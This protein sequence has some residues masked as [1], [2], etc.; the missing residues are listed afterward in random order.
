MADTTTDKTAPLADA[1]AATV[2]AAAVTPTPPTPPAEPV[3]PLSPNVTTQGESNG[4]PPAAPGVQL[5]PPTEVKELREWFQKHVFDSVHSKDTPHYNVLYELMQ[6]MCAKL[7][8]KYPLSK[9]A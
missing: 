3:V 9:E 4:L 8:S 7:H 2:P 1:P 6:S 5:E